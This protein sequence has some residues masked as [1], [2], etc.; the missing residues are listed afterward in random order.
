MRGPSLSAAAG[1]DLAVALLLAALFASMCVVGI[2]ETARARG[3]AEV[4]LT[5]PQAAPE[6]PAEVDS[7]SAPL[8]LLCP[9]GVLDESA[10]VPEP[11][12]TQ[13]ASVRIDLLPGL[14]YRSSVA[15]PP[16][17]T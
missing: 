2:G 16:R 10:V 17:R 6:A 3:P 5:S 13:L 7:A 4:V 15:P 8:G 9:A 1:R 12:W 11:T 14:A